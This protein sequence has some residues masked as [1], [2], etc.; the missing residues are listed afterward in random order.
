M[1]LDGASAP[2]PDE[3]DGFVG[4]DATD[5]SGDRSGELEQCESRLVFNARRGL[6]G[7]LAYSGCLVPVD[8][9]K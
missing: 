1:P 2:G 7:A 3:A 5:R 8:K 9:L 6:G 4:V